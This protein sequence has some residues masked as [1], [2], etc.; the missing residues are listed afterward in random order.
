[1]RR[2]G[3]F[4]QVG[5]MLCVSALA[6]A[7][8]A[9]AGDERSAPVDLGTLGGSSSQAEAVSGNGNVAG[10]ATLTDDS[11]QHAFVLPRGLSSLQDL[12]TLTGGSNSSAAGVNYRG[13]V[14]GTSEYEDP[15]FGLVNHG[16]FYNSGVLADIGTLGGSTSRANALNSSGVAVGSSLLTDEATT[17]AIFWNPQDKSLIDLGTLDGGTNSAAYGINDWFVAAG[18]SENGSVD[19]S[20]S[21]IV[22]A[23]IFL[24]KNKKVID[25][26]NLGA[27]PA[28]AT[29][30]NNYNTV[31][32]FSAV[33]DGST[34]GFVWKGGKMRDLGG[35]G[36]SYT[37]AT[38]V[39]R[40]NE[41]VGFSN[42]TGDASAHAFVWTKKTGIVDLNAL[43]P[44][45][46]GWEL[47]A[48]YG[49]NDRGEIVGVGTYNGESHAFS[50]K[51][52]LD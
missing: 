33:A 44:T 18:S 45:K 51:C 32:G 47:S 49:V 27:S 13:E 52:P 48:A 34:H 1:M 25:I 15:E 10:F 50:L 14:V 19:A 12:G 29:A 28:Q 38:A 7:P 16:F 3:K 2:T 46:S 24:L 11:A 39:N 22:D 21:P 20:G 35:L 6:T 8:W 40:S 23:V 43:I 36:G 5:V 31:V 17:H 42:L 30:I 41:V 37:Q 26:G 4:M 9:L